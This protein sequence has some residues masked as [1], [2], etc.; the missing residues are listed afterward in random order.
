MIEFVKGGVK[1]LNNH[2]P[3]IRTY[4]LQ[5]LSPFLFLVLSIA[6]LHMSLGLNALPVCVRVCVCACVRVCVCACVRVCVCA[7]VRVC[8]CARVRVCVSA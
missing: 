2:S 3:N 7:C 5:Y 8:A 1:R 4:N 6:D